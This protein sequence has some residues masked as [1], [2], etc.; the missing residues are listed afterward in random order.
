MLFTVGFVDGA[1]MSAR[2]AKVLR[3]DILLLLQQLTLLEPESRFEDKPFKFQV[4]GPKNGTA[5][6]KALTGDCN[7]SYYYSSRAFISIYMAKN[8]RRHRVCWIS[9]RVQ[10]EKRV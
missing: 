9:T 2:L 6:L 5:V 1:A 10:K 4:V 8:Q 3:R 7:R